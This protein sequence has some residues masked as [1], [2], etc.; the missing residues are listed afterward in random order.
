M[1]KT[2]YTLFLT[3]LLLAFSCTPSIEKE[4]RGLYFF[5]FG[6]NSTDNFYSLYFGKDS[7]VVGDYF[8]YDQLGNYQIRKD[9]VFFFLNGLD[10]IA[11]KIAKLD[12]EQLCLVE[13]FDSLYYSRI[14]T[15]WNRTIPFYPYELSGIHTGNFIDSI[16]NFSTIHYFKMDGRARIRLNDAMKNL[17]DLE[18]F[19]EPG[20]S[21]LRAP[22]YC[23]IGEGITVFDLYQLY[24]QL[25]QIGLTKTTLVLAK[26]G[27]NRF[28]I[29][30]DRI[31]FVSGSPMFDLNV[32]TN[33]VKNSLIT[34]NSFTEVSDSNFSQMGR[35]YYVKINSDISLME[36]IKIKEKLKTIVP[37]E[38]IKI[39]FL[40]P[41]LN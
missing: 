19:L 5:Q 28:E 1:R 14:P 9:S 17:E 33:E 20:H 18:P 25:A 3:A 7:L 41:S 26:S 16:R 23:L 40:I 39:D 31:G 34:L 4:I 22:I 10:V 32:D 6:T 38:A 27:K 30:E 11:Y 2:K 37:E 13:G 36:Y 15:E 29:F 12:D 21:G 8:D 35:L 24:E